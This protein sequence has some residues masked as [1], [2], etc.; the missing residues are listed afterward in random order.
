[1]F[2]FAM[3]LLCFNLGLI[4]ESRQGSASVGIGVRMEIGIRSSMIRDW[5]WQLG[6]SLDLS[7]LQAKYEG[8]N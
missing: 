5:N 3:Y 6:W 2:F 1:M 4:P 7:K 8:A